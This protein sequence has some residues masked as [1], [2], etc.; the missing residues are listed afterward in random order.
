MEMN[1]DGYLWVWVWGSRTPG[2]NFL[3]ACIQRNVTFLTFEQYWHS[4]QILNW[5]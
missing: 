5:N 3:L 2:Y 4:M 1:E